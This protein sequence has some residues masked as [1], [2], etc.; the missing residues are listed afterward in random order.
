MGA[1]VHVLVSLGLVRTSHGVGTFV[2][3]PGHQASLLNYAWREASLGELAM[4]RAAIDERAPALF[5]GRMGRPPVAVTTS[6]ISDLNFFAVER[7]AQRH[8]SAEQFVAAD[9]AFHATIL[10]G[11]Q[12]IEIGR[13]LYERIGER[14]RPTLEAAAPDVVELE[15]LDR[16]HRALAHA[17]AEGDLPRAMR[18]SRFVARCELHSTNVALG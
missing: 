16:A 1:A 6:A 9:L 7:S 18:T 17:V 14:L 5:A 15:E 4:V 10:N 3:A 11:L 12:G 2:T 8:G 13:V